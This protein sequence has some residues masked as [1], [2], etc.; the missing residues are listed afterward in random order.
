MKFNLEKMKKHMNITSEIRGKQIDTQQEVGD[1][2]GIDEALISFAYAN[3][4]TK[5]LKKIIK[6]Q[7]EE[8]EKTR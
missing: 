4:S 7:E 1:M 3:I 5:G 2:Y 8:M 6:K